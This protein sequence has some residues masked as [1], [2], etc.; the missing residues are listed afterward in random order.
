MKRIVFLIVI[1]IAC[2]G[3]MAFAEGNVTV[4]TYRS[5][6]E[7]AVSNSIQPELDDYNIKAK[8]SALEDAKEEA[9]KGFLGGTPQEV[10]ERMIIR[11]VV[12]LEAE[13][14]LEVA[15]R[16]KT[17]NENQLKA[18]VYQEMMRVLFAQE[19]VALKREKLSL[20]EERFRIDTIQYREGLIPEADII[21]EELALNIEK[22]DLLKM[23]TEMKSV[24][25]DM[26]QRLHVDLSDENQI[27]FD[28]KLQ[29][30]GT[31]YVL[32]FFDLD[33]AIKKALEA[34]TEVYQKQKAVEAAEKKLEITKEHLKP[35][36]EFYD[37][38]EYELEAAE[39]AF[40]DAKT[41]L[42][43]SIRNAHN[44]LLTVLDAYE[45][46]YKK[47]ELEESRLDVLKVK[48]DAGLISRRDMIDTEINVV[49]CKQEV[50]Q[51][52]RDFN[53]KNDILRHLLGE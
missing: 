6:L 35:G 52:I 40:Y 12:P 13:V 7:A 28:Y 49:S 19:N 41:N 53:I 25:L 5:A 14:A 27:A 47:L 17:D 50:L 36:N 9:I 29:K 34:N 46:A 10:A 38:K 45:L 48:F 43:V 44:E 11:H 31:H 33:S 4:F 39:K 15:R 22:L 26:K 3:I 2:T 20:M 32:D 18:D 37:Q 8:E 1:L 23:E 24:I 42:E 30:I 51:A 16:Q 21:N